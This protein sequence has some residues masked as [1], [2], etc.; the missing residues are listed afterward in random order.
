MTRKNWQI[1]LENEKI[2]PYF[3]QLIKFLDQEYATK[4]IYP[5]REDLFSCF[6][7]TPYENIKVVILGQDPYHGPNQAHGL[8]FS[9]RKGVK[10]PPSLIN[11]YKELESDLQI[12]PVSHGSLLEW[13][14]QGVFM[15]N[16]V[17]SVEKGKAGSHQNQGWETFTDHAIAYLNE[18]ETPIVFLLWG[19]WAQGKESLIDTNKHHVIKS[20]HP[21]PFAA[22]YGFFG[23][24]PFSKTNAYLRKDGLSEIDWQL[25]E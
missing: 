3:I 4:T 15:M 24:K 14:K 21:S 7:S 17:M 18:H 19:K 23:S 25:H 1:F 8:S 2:Q 5:Q 13:A 9:V 12:K 16:A 22:A 20:A 10:T 6:L 11:I